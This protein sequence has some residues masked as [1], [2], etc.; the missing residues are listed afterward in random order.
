[1]TG[2][3]SAAWELRTLGGVAAGQVVASVSLYLLTA[4]AIAV[5]L[6]RIGSFRWWASLG[7]PLP[8]FVFMAVF[9][10]SWWHTR[11]RRSVVWRGRAI[12]LSKST[13]TG[14]AASG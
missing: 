2:T 12:D 6:R 7:F 3:G 10:R 5:Q 9:V 8:M 11:V 14:G 1:M 4:L 13:S